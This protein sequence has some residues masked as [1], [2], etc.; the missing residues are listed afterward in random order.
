MRRFN[1]V[2]VNR[3]NTKYILDNGLLLMKGIYI[4]FSTDY[5]IEYETLNM[6]GTD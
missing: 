4:Y 1:S 5:L 6:I 2:P 3:F